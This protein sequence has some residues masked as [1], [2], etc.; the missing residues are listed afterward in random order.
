[1]Q[2]LHKLGQFFSDIVN[3]RSMIIVMALQEMR[4]RYAG[5]YVGAFWAVINPL[6]TVAI[7]WM[8]FSVGFKVR[9]GGDIPFIAFFLAGFVAWLTFQEILSTS[10]DCVTKS[11]YL[12]K[13]IIFPVNILP[14]IHLTLGT[15]THAFLLIILIC[16][17]WVSDVEI[18]WAALGAFYYFFAMMVFAMGLCWLVSALNVFFRDVSHGLTIVMASW[19]WLTPVVWPPEILPESYRSWLSFNPMYYIVQ[20]YRESFLYDIPFWESSGS[21]LAFWVITLALLF[22]GAYTFRRLRPFF[23]EVL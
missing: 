19:F 10:V 7:Y 12:V 15:V 2:F 11:S 1:M 8:V 4:A 3:F 6:F 17:L 21:H 13:K 23:A 18:H 9:P 20:G 5:S 22:L 14:L 16:V